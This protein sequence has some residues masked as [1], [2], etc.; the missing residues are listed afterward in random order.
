MQLIHA[1]LGLLLV[2]LGLLIALMVIDEPAFSTGA[3]HGLYA[4]MN[5]GGDGLVRLGSATWLIGWLGATSMLLMVL[6]SAFGVRAERRSGVFWVLIVIAAAGAEFVWWS[7]YLE[8]L[9]FLR[10][11]DANFVLSF[12]AATSWML[13]GVWLSGAVL[14]LIYIFGFRHFVFTHADEAAYEA[15]RADAE[16]PRLPPEQHKS[17]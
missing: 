5:V 13:Y 15:L 12:P 9:A 3:A 14:A 17:H 4:G 2:V 8:Y 16:T 7:M 11:G 10:T 1:V 6:L